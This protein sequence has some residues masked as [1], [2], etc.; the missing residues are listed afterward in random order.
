MGQPK[1]VIPIQTGLGA[2]LG[3]KAESWLPS[4]C[5][6]NSIVQTPPNYHKIVQRL[7]ASRDQLSLAPLS[8]PGCWDGEGRDIH[9]SFGEGFPPTPFFCHLLCGGL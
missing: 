8:L 5:F 6:Y 9:Y 2:G 4:L 1:Y 3:T 7:R